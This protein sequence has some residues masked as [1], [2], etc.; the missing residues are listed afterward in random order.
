[1]LTV[2]LEAPRPEVMHI[3]LYNPTGQ[4]VWE[5]TLSLR[6]GYQTLRL[7]LPTLPSGRYWLQLHA[8]RQNHGQAIQIQ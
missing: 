5:N 2:A 1:M 7:R 6:T 4:R 8:G 3:H